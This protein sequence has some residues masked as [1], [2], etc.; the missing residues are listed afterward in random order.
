LAAFPSLREFITALEKAGELK[1]ISR[2]VSCDLEIAAVSDLEM[3]SPGGGKALLFEKVTGHSM[4]VLVNAYGS[5]KRIAMVLGGDPDLHAARIEELLHLAPPAGIGEFLKLLPRIASLRSV[6]PKKKKSGKPPCQEVVLTGEDIDLT[7]IPV[8]TCWPDDGGPFVTLP[9]VVTKDPA[10]GRQNVGMYRLQIFD[11]KTTGMHWHIHKDGSVSHEAHRR[12]GKRMEVAVA[13]GTDP[14][15][16]YAATA[17]LPQGIDEFMFAGFL[18]E[19]P[20]ELARCAT[21]DLWV[22]ATAEIILEGYVEPGETRIEGPFGDHTGYYSPAD[23][24]PVFHLTA[25]THRKNPVYFATVVGI[26]PM[27]DEWLGWATERLFL[28]LL[29]TNWPEVMEMH[30]PVE[31]VFHNLC[32]ASI[33]KLYPMQARRLMSGF[34]GAG[35]MSFTKTICV[36]DEKDPVRDPAAALRVVLDRIRIPEDLVFSEGVMDAL[37]HSSPHPLWGGKLGVDATVKIEGE[38]G[39]GEILSASP[40]AEPEE[41]YSRLKGHFPGLVGCLMPVRGARLGL[42][43]LVLEK[44]APGEGAKL[45]RSALDLPGVDIAVAVEGAKGEAL[46]VLAW[47]VFSSVDPK[48]DIV[49]TGNKLAVDATFKHGPEEGH[50]RE[51][52]KEVSHPPEVIAKARKLLKDE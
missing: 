10:T 19:K 45:A 9:C 24:Y 25:I 20:V 12:L 50:F 27:E 33:R 17:P 8:L 48:R 5:K 51:W 41:V 47:R 3:K 31:G 30:L 29:R 11:K 4:P 39:A 23:P 37:D 22:P 34:W 21:V 42:F 32:L 26:P 2:E 40:A 6:V 44:S 36:M 28:P 35:Q 43:L 46:S 18:R 16:T 7:K 15:V 49:V 38:P 13:I 52:P 14:A 1:R